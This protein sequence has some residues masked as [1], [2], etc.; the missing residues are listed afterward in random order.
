MLQVSIFLGKHMIVF[1]LI[2]CSLVAVSDGSCSPRCQLGSVCCM[3]VCLVTSC[4]GHYCVTSSDCSWSE[5]CCSSEC[6]QGSGC[7]GRSCTHDYDC[8]VG[9]KCCLDV[10]TDTQKCNCD[11]DSDCP[12]G[13]ICCHGSCSEKG[14]CSANS[15]NNPTLTIVGSVLGSLVL[16]S[17][18]SIFIYLI[19]RRRCKIPRKSGDIQTVPA[20]VTTPNNTAQSVPASHTAENQASSGTLYVPQNVYGAIPSRQIYSTH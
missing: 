9:E 4:Q 11:H 16:I 17:L 10:C 1:L 14:D 8:D 19:Y 6:A 13:K 2:T 3:G 18:I 20:S 7:A 12:I 15:Y 5:T